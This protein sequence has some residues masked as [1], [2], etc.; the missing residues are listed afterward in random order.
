M[1]GMQCISFLSCTH[2]WYTVG[3]L[4]IFLFSRLL[5]WRYLFLG[6]ALADF[7]FFW[8]NSERVAQ[9]WCLVRKLSVGSDGSFPLQ[10]I[11]S[12][13]VVTFYLRERNGE[14]T[15]RSKS[16]FLWCPGCLSFSCF[17]LPF[18]FLG[19]N[20]Q[21]GGL[22]LCLSK[23]YLVR[24]CDQYVSG[25]EQPELFQSCLWSP[26][27]NIQSFRTSIYV[28]MG[29]HRHHTYWWMHCFASVRF[30]FLWE[31]QWSRLIYMLSKD[32][33]LLGIKFGFSGS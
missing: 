3:D 11:T 20:L 32:I 10:A 30:A 7:F 33:G 15:N 13:G 31:K 2:R 26:T 21:H 8:R 9:F 29:Y 12:V 18:H 14:I 22:R 17:L 4:Y 24:F 25:A 19:T 16:S 27:A 28:R 23:I 6:R 5:A 1:K